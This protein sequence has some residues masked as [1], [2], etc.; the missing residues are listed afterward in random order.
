MWH[1]P[2]NQ[3]HLYWPIMLKHTRWKRWWPGLCDFAGSQNIVMPLPPIVLNLAFPTSL[4]KNNR[5]FYFGCCLPAFIWGRGEKKNTWAS[6]SGCNVIPDDT[7]CTVGRDLGEVGRHG[8]M[9]SGV[10]GKHPHKPSQWLYVSRP[11]KCSMPPTP[12]LRYE[13]CTANAK[14]CATNAVDADV[15][16]EFKVTQTAYYRQ[17]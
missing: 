10:A 6:H 14:G 2:K 13:N 15:C 3:N 7:N 12:Q 1:V 11:W 17:H 8:H 9:C 5:N 16:D 4:S